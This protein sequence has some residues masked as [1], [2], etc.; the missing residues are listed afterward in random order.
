[1]ASLMMPVCAQ[2]VFVHSIA[3]EQ[4]VK[5]ENEPPRWY[6]IAGIR[7]RGAARKGNKEIDS[8]PILA[9][10]THQLQ[11]GELILFVVHIRKREVLTSAAKV[12]SENAPKQRNC[13]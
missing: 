5:N 1:M 3:E 10:D 11:W 9:I 13:V 8:R 7:T 12:V 4:K 2:Y 6:Q